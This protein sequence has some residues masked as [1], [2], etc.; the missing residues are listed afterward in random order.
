M[1]QYN[2]PAFS[3]AQHLQQ[4][5][6]RGL[7]IP[8]MARAERYLSNISYYRLS[9]YAIPHCQAPA[10]AHQFRA[11]T[12]F[13]DILALYIFDRELRLLV[14]DAIERIEVAVRTQMS[15]YMATTYGNNPFWY[16]DEVHVKSDYPHKRF[17]ADI[18]RQLDDERRRLENDERHVDKRN[19][20][21]PAQ[22]TALK[23]K[24]R[25]ENFLR[26]YLCSYDSPRLPPC[27]MMMEML[28]WGSLSK[29]YAGLRKQ[30]DQKAIARLMGTNAEL[31]ESWLKTLNTVR[32]FCAHHAR[33]W[34]R[35]LGVSIKLPN[36]SQVR[37]LQQ[38]VTL[39]DPHI[40][41]EKR[42]YPVLVA[43]QSLL[44]TISPSSHW[45]QRLQELMQR[46][47]RVSLAHMGMPANWAAD[48]FWQDALKA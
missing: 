17:L 20:L 28:T 11:N 1:N 35:E 39:A 25:K 40:R 2:K 44:Y 24:L 26:H 33:L 47:P 23:A 27:W 10:Q 14:M 12:S 34:N 6:Q 8:D 41:F 38:P 37:W 5:Q 42:L 21:T 15:N 32:N 45:A 13:D 7:L 29:L 43:L 19:N 18:E 16:L 31:L 4:W 22:K 48:P 30:A 9:A 3:T 36:S 46:Y